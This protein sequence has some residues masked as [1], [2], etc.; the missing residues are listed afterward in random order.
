MHDLCYVVWTRFDSAGR[1]A[2]SR[3]GETNNLEGR[4]RSVQRTVPAPSGTRRKNY[5]PIDTQ[6][7]LRGAGLTLFELTRAEADCASETPVMGWS[8]FTNLFGG[9]VRTEWMD[10]DK[11]PEYKNFFYATMRAQP[12]APTFPGQPG[13]LLCLPATLSTPPG[14]D[15]STISMLSSS[16]GGGHLKY[17]GEYARRPLPDVQIK[18]D[19][20]PPTVRTFHDCCLL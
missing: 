6:T 7:I 9:R 10:C 8:A 15:G 12:F 5:T 17:L 20:L 18:W 16:L 2:L 13:L 11:I 4:Y 3:P 1:S 19:D 14:N